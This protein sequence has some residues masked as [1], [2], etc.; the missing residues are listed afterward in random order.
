MLHSL[1]VDVLPLENVGHDS[2]LELLVV[3]PELLVGLALFD[4]FAV[5]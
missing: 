1:A 5:S 2:N 4:Y 3:V